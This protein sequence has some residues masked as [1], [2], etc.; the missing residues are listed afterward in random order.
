VTISLILSLCKSLGVSI[1][2]FVLF[3]NGG[4]WCE[5]GR[6]CD[7]KRDVEFEVK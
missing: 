1:M 3:L 6:Q 7:Y 4:E 5:H 2:F